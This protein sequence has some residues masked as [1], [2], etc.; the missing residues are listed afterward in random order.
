MES[1]TLLCT[2]DQPPRWL[3]INDVG[4]TPDEEVTVGSEKYHHIFI[5]EATVRAQQTTLHMQGVHDRR[6]TTWSHPAQ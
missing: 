1:V 5:N 2:S 6:R 4:R 3:R